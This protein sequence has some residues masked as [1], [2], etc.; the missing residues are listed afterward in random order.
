MAESGGQHLRPGALISRY[1][2]REVLGAGGFGITYKAFDTRLQCEVAIKEYLP[3]EF[4]IRESN[5][6]TVKPRNQDIAEL[7]QHNRAILL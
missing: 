2:V 6:A 7:Y 1:E 5:Q 4:A 3:A